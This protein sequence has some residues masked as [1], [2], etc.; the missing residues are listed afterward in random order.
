MFRGSRAWSQWGIVRRF[1]E[2]LACRKFWFWPEEQWCPTST[3]H[4][5]VNGGTAVVESRSGY[6][7][8]YVTQD[9]FG[10]YFLERCN[11][12]RYRYHQLL[13]FT[14]R[15]RQLATAVLHRDEVEQWNTTGRFAMKPV[16]GATRLWSTLHTSEQELLE[17][18]GFD[19]SSW[20]TGTGLSKDAQVGTV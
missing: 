1:H 4:T 10:R 3:C 14:S 16:P 2:L 18:V 6:H 20:D 11:T 19:A 9:I 13:L 5:S 17:T 15:F 8:L 7:K 12:I